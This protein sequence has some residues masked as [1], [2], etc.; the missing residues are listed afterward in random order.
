MKEI[1]IREATADDIPAIVGV[2]RAAFTD[3]EVRGFTPPEHSMFYSPREL[4]RAWDKDDRLKNGWKVAVAQKSREIVGFIVFGM[5]GD[6]GFIDNLNVTKQQEGKGVGRALVNYVEDVAKA[7]GCNVM[8]TD[9]TENAEGV[10]WKSYGFWTKM[11]YEDTGER[12]PTEWDFKEI[13]FV[14]NLT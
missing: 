14:K 4:R 2:R 1:A 8:E 3:E 10:P 11:G 5:K 13:R 9:T 7:A 6:F 12:L